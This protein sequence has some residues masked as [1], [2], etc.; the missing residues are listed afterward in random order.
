ML[1]R[2]ALDAATRSTEISISS[3]TPVERRWA[4]EVLGHDRAEV[5]LSF[6][7]SGCAPLLYQHDPDRL[8]GVVERAWI[9]SD[10]KGRAVVRFGN[11][12]IA[13]RTLQ[14]VADGILTNV[15]VGCRIDSMVLIA[16]DDRVFPASSDLL[17][18][19]AGSVNGSR[20]SLIIRKLV[21]PDCGKISASDS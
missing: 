20:A 10:R 19:A 9:D 7:G 8:I 6:M 21:V 11:S 4:T 12:D 1:D 15:S 17:K 2:A 3:E 5:D 18:S 16:E 14:D 13:E